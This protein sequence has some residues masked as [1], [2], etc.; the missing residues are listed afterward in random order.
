[1]ENAFASLRKLRILPA[2]GLI[3][4]GKVEISRRVKTLLGIALDAGVTSSG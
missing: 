2:C 3:A 4:Q 1:M